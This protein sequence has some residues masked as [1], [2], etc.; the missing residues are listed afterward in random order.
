[1]VKIKEMEWRGRH[2]HTQRERDIK[3]TFHR[4]RERERRVGANCILF[5]LIEHNLLPSK[6]RLVVKYKNINIHAQT[7]HTHTC[8]YIYIYILNTLNQESGLCKWNYMKRKRTKKLYSKILIKS[9]LIIQRTEH[10]SH[11][12]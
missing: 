3:K 8:A 6:I 9:N 11:L 2:T 7:T 12:Y 4:E 1:M 10:T 5:L